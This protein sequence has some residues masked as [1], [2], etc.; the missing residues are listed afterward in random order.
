MIIKIDSNGIVETIKYPRLIQ[1]S[2]K[3]NVITLFAAVEEDY[4]VN[5]N[6]RLHSGTYSTLMSERES[7]EEGYRCWQLEI[8]NGITKHAGQIQL[9]FQLGKD[10]K[11]IKTPIIQVS[12]EESIDEGLELDDPD[13]FNELWELI[14]KRVSKEDLFAD[15]KIKNELLPPID[16]G[17][18]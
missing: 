7:E 3:A 11:I 1:G 14:N 16:C 2:N 15:G 8:T 17:S 4:F 5:A 10:D 18:W 9:A 13:T 12:V 6:F